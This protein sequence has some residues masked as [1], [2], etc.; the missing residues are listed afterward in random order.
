MFIESNRKPL[1]SEHKGIPGGS[2]VK[3]LPAM[4]EMQVWSLG[5]EDPLESEMA[6]HCSI[7]AWRTPQTEEPG[8]LGPIGSQRVRH[9]WVTE[10]TCAVNTYYVSGTVLDASN[11]TQGKDLPSWSLHSSRKRH[12]SA[13]HTS[14]LQTMLVGEKGY[15]KKL[16]QVKWVESA[17]E[18]R[19]CSSN[20]IVTQVTEKGEECSRQGPQGKGPDLGGHWLCTRSKRPRAQKAR[21]PRACGCCQVFDFFNK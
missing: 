15:R 12:L 20:Q 7:L 6:N 19:V 4:Q 9:D 11:W 3:N 13:Y 18:R 10:Q 21:S 16:S 14:K 2:V 8:G 17:S 1:F 5:R